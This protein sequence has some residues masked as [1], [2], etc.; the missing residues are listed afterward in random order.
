LR[1][2][3]LVDDPVHAERRC[4]GVERFTIVKLDALTQAK[5][6]GV[7]VY[8][9][10]A[11]SEPGDDLAIP[12]AIQQT[13]ENVAARDPGIAIDHRLTVQGGR[14]G[15]HGQHQRSR[16]SSSRA[17]Q[18]KSTGQEQ[19]NVP[20]QSRLHVTPPG[21]DSIRSRPVSGKRKRFLAPLEMT[22]DV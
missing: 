12:I 10:I 6:P 9:T 4:F 7:V 3:F 15:C 13:L 2:K 18:K 5:P 22:S 16:R 20:K 19:P 14:F 17:E 21:S 1:L 8:G 11:F